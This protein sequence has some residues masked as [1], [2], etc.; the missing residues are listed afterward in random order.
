MAGVYEGKC[1]KCGTKL[2]AVKRLRWPQRE[3]DALWRA[4][5]R[6][7]RKVTP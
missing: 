5:D 6:L 1:P 4:F 7:M 2:R 3:W